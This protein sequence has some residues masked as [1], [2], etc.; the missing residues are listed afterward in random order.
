MAK[1]IL[2][3][4]VAIFLLGVLTPHLARFIRFG[5]LP[6]DFTI[7]LRGRSYAF[8]FTTILLLSLLLWLLGRLL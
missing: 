2:T 5:R 6:G 7:R 3:L 8:P 1:W 4:I